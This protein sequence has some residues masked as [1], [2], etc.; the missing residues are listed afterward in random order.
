MQTLVICVDRAGD[1]SRKSDVSPPVSGWDDVESLVIEFGL[2]DPEDSS[3]NTLLESLQVTQDLQESGETAEV[4]V[5]SSDNDS[6]V[7]ADRLVATQIDDLLTRYD[8][9]SVIVVTDS[10]EDER[11]VPIIESRVAVDSVDRVVV[12]QS[13]DIESTYYL[14]KQFLGDEELR[15]T[16]L[17]PIGIVLLVFPALMVLT[18]SLTLALASITAVL[19]LF[20]LYKGLGIDRYIA[21]LPVQARDALYSGRVSIVTYVVAGGLALVGIFVG[22]LSVSNLSNQIG[23]LVFSMLFIYNSVPW[24]AS[25]ALAASAGR[26]LDDAIQNNRLR[27]SYLN[28]PFGVVAVGFVIRGFSGYF[29]QRATIIGPFTIPQ[30]HFS[31]I[32]IQSVSLTAEERLAL[33]VIIGIIISI[34]G[35]R[36]ATYLA[37]TEFDGD[38]SEEILEQEQ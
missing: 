25:A 24:L 37:G 8:P 29:L 38:R 12:R 35:I 6:V 4:A 20:L 17:V 1:V 14:L 19:G 32:T 18:G 16:T 3:V 11:L 10:A 34:V 23:S 30:L 31:V 7:N 21:H 2:A 9:D 13:R 28:L 5:V 26:L 36:I 22:A 33:F 27:S 15:Q